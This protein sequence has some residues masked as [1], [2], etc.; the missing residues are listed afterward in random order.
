MCFR[1]PFLTC[2]ILPWQEVFNNG[3]SGLPDGAYYLS[4]ES[5]FLNVHCDIICSVPTAR[6]ESR[7]S[8]LAPLRQSITHR[9][10]HEAPDYV[11]RWVI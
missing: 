2:A 9:R 3:F 10:W 5:G 1:V 7:L 11:P 4:F 8:R 6:R